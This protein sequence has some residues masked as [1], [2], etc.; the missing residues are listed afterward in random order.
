MSGSMYPPHPTHSLRDMQWD[1]CS[2]PE[3]AAQ[4]LCRSET[5]SFSGLSCFRIRAEAAVPVSSSTR[6]PLELTHTHHEFSGPDQHRKSLS[7]GL[8]PVY[9]THWNIMKGLV[10]CSV[11]HE[12]LTLRTQRSKERHADVIR[13]HR[14][15]PNTRPDVCHLNPPSKTW[16]VTLNQ[17]IF[18]CRNWTGNWF[19]LS[20]NWLNTVSA[21][22][23]RFRFRFHI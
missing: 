10:T 18:I 21:D 11:Q 16:T 17:F 7:V 22:W 6:L 12:T 8:I 3:S 4:W 13:L 20:V 1:Q 15:E 14:S 5:Q 2:F 23:L 9:Q 19:F